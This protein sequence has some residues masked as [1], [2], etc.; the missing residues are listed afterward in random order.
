MSTTKLPEAF[1]RK[2]IIIAYGGRFSVEERSVDFADGYN[3]ALERTG[4]KELWE[5][6]LLMQKAMRGVGDIVM[7]YGSD[8]QRHECTQALT[9]ARAA[10]EEVANHLKEEEER[11]PLPPGT[12]IVHNKKD[13]VFIHKVGK[14]YCVGIFPQEGYEGGCLDLSRDQFTIKTP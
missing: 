14:L 13:G 12:R 4:A 8:E 6:L 3:S 9:A 1:E 2:K 11:K 5:A 10:P 7:A